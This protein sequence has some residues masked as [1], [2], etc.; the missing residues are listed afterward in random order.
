M[1]MQPFTRAEAVEVWKERF[2]RKDKTEQLCTCQNRRAL[3]TRSTY[4]SLY[5]LLDRMESARMLRLLLPILLC[6]ISAQDDG[7]RSPD[8]DLVRAHEMLAGSWKFVSMT[9]KG[10]T[11][12]STLLGDKFARDGVLTVADR[13]M[14]IVSPET[15]EKRTATFRIDPGKTP[16]QIDLVTRDDRIFRGIY[17]FEDSDLVVCLQPGDSIAR[18]EDFTAPNDSDRIL[19]RLK[20]ISRKSAPARSPASESANDKTRD[21]T[22]TDSRLRRAHELLAG[23][24]DVVSI[25]DDGSTLAADLIQA[26]FAENGRIQIGTKEVAFVSPQSG[27]RRISAIHIDPTKTPF[28]IDVTTH[29]DEVLKGMSY[30]GGR[31]DAY[32]TSTMDPRLVGRTYH[33]R[34]QSVGDNTM[35]LAN[36]FGELRTAR[37]IQ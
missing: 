37:R 11:L 21:Q 24:W 28:Q 7:A 20:T 8:G 30:G 13:R 2:T 9:D 19:V 35:V 27:E 18:P 34:L 22:P 1:T 4:R 16:R 5:S 23:S 32:V 31:L 14:T 17:K 10:E 33:F 15:G 3:L 6:A 29:F 25:I 36:S 26:K 12:G